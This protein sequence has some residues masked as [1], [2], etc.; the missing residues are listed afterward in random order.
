[1]SQESNTIDSNLP[2][3]LL[4][5][6]SYPDR[7]AQ[8]VLIDTNSA[9]IF[10]AGERAYKVK[11]SVRFPFLDFSTLEQ[12]H[13][14][15][16]EE[17]R[18]NGFLAPGVYRRVL[19]ITREKT[20]LRIGGTG[21]PV[22]Y[23][24][25]MRRLPEHRML[26]RLLDEGQVDN[27]MMSNLAEVLERF[28]AQSV[29][30]PAAA[31]SPDK[32]LAAILENLH[33][34]EAI[35]EPR[36]RGLIARV[37][38][39]SQTWVA[40]HRAVMV[41]RAD[42]GRIKDG[43][44][45]LHA[46]NICFE[47]DRITIFDR[48]EFKEKFRQIDVGADLAFLAMDLDRRGFQAFGD[49]F[50][51]RYGELA[52]DDT[53]LELNPLYKSHRASIRAKVAQMQWQADR[54]E[55]QRGAA[56]AHLNLAASY[57]LTGRAA[58]V[59]M[60]GLP[61]TG[62]TFVARRL[63]SKLGAHLLRSDVIRKR[64]RTDGAGARAAPD[65]Y[66]ADAVLRNYDELLATARQQLAQGRIAILDATFDRRSLRER[67]RELAKTQG[68]PTAVVLVSADEATVRARLEQRAAEHTEMSDADLAVYLAKRKTFEEPRADESGII[69]H[70]SGDS[71]DELVTDLLL[72]LTD[73]GA[74]YNGGNSSGGD[75]ER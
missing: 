21:T 24:L 71:I 50:L 34:L 74:A 25:E 62:K 28:H 43:H 22:E 56:L 49:Y 73:P 75:H 14:Y 23:A 45:D 2:R 57:A 15:L 36:A 32:I 38:D 58:L 26:E 6:A 9:W 60:C 11:K 52:R 18:L 31:G 8:I 5:P 42:G 35:S 65:A 46:G 69:R 66:S 30:L 47:E 39:F 19:P 33:E 67:A 55:R 51:R 40:D 41:A 4:E 17:V 59:L 72:A 7:P 54:D 63:A 48:I 12:R 61:G 27:A 3:A 13:H 16:E 1:M 44:G 20:S 53:L 68:A 64:A 10:L 37:R 29:S 70:A